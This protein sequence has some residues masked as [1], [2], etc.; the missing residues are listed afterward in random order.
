MFTELRN[1]GGLYIALSGRDDVTLHPLLTFLLYNFT[2]TRYA[3][4]LIDI[5]VKVLD[6]YAEGKRTGKSPYCC[7]TF[8]IV[9]YL[10]LGQSA[11][12]DELL[13]KLQ[14]KVAKEVQYQKELIQLEG[15]IDLIL[16]AA[17][18]KPPALSAEQ[19]S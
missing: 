9:L 11:M 5:T 15:A 2:N 7:T 1:R 3:I 12:I 16:T 14:A 18:S 10:V 13:V 19:S 17:A 6:M 8:L 4:Q